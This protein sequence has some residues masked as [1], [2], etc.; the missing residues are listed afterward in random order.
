[1]TEFWSNNDRGYRI[2]LWLDQ[3]S[4]NIAGNSS[5]VRVRLALLNTTTTFA[6]YNCSA[7]VDL[8]GQRLNWSGSP[9]MTSWN[10][11]IML[12]D[13]TI[14]VNH[15][16]DGTKQFGFIAGFNGSGGW[17]PGALNISPGAF[18]L[19]TIP[20]T[21]SF[22]GQTVA[23]GSN[24]SITIN[25]A[26]GS[27]T[28]NLRYA[29]GSKT[30]T[31]ATGVA[32]SA[33]WSVPMDFAN[34]M[35]NA[36]SGR[37][38]I[39]CDTYSG[40]TK[41]GTSHYI[42]TLTIP[43]TVKPSFTGFTLE[44]TNTKV[45]ALLKANTFAQILS[46][47][48]ATFNGATG[49][50]GST[51]K[52][53]RAEVVGKNLSISEQGGIF[54]LMN[55]KGAAVIRGYVTDSRG[56]E[57]APREIGI[58][59][60]EYFKPSISVSVVRSGASNDILQ[61]IRTVKIAPLTLDNI[62][63]NVMKVLVSTA[64]LGSETYTSNIGASATFTTQSTLTASTVNLSGTY[65]ANQE[66]K[67]K[68]VVE[69]L[70][71]TGNE[72][73][74]QIGTEEVVSSKAQNAYGFGKIVTKPKVL[75]SAWPVHAPDF[76][77]NG[78]SLLDIFY[79]VGTIYTSNSSANPSTFMGGTWTRFGNGKVL[80][81][82]SENEVEFNTIGKTGGEK[83]HKLTQAEMPSHSHSYTSSG[84][85]NYVKVEPS[86]TFGRSADKQATTSTA[87]GDQPHNNLQPYVTVYYWL[88]T[89]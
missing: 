20:R 69:D 23:V 78:K 4:Q 34:E 2:R 31:I 5:Q 62:Q 25:R 54:P 11:T 22:S 42:F 16:A 41:I 52:S 8:N 13:Q 71:T 24:M 12:I 40:S 39:W 83:T 44:D 38:T 55:F 53:Y 60:R 9:D 82:V 77:L 88:R 1:M 80:V 3:T 36:T 67:V 86:S 87:G 28:H 6:Q 70:F 51:I 50:Y 21:S 46:L 43:D 66:F 15:N 18:T 59:L 85:Q 64:P 27:F 49:A 48:K 58:N 19:S 47:V 63:K 29:F 89:A 61:I 57:S 35:S 33:T 74:A 45:K 10:S 17:S 65:P 14:T 75:D 73:V 7:Y 37:G 68:A 76:V 56:R 81:G 72:V 26:S 84:A 79:P 30:G 32:T